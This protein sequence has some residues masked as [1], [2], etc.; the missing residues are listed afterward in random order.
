MASSELPESFDGQWIAVETDSTHFKADIKNDE[1]TIEWVFEDG[2]NALY[3][4]GSVAVGDVF[5]ST[6]NVEKTEF[7]L[8]A[9]QLETKEFRYE[10]GHICFDYKLMGVSAVAKLKPVK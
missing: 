2:T 10:D 5:T 1:M 4:I 9:S 8:F 3:W 7:A 6:R